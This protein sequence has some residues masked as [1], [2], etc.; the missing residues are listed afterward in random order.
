MTEDPWIDPPVTFTVPMKRIPDWDLVSHSKHPERKLTPPLPMI[1][2]ETAV[3][4]EKAE[5][6]HLAL[7]PYG[8]THLRVAVF[9]TVRL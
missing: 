8:A 1:D 3:S 4:L 5:V 7:V 2:H 6:Q 9:P